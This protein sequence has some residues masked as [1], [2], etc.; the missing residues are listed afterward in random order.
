LLDAEALCGFARFCDPNGQV[1][2]Q[3]A[4]TDSPAVRATF[5]RQVGNCPSGRLV[6]RDR[7][8]QK[9]V[10]PHLPMSIGLVEDPAQGCSGPLWLRGRIPVV[11]ADG[12][13]YEVRNRV[14]LCRCGESKNKPFCDGTH[15][16]I[17]FRD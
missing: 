12:F 13:E 16:S 14:T 8:T 3:V 7:S 9:D 2:N 4:Q 15:A 6:A 17:K 5:S 10:E 1:W 11:A